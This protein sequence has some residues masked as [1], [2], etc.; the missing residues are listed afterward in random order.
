MFWLYSIAKTVHFI[1]LIS[2]FAGLFYLPRLFI[3]HT[4]AFD[5]EDPQIAAALKNQFLLMEKKLYSIIMTPAMIITF[6]G[7]FSMIGIGIAQGGMIWFLSQTWLLLKLFFIFLL[8]IY[9]HY[10]LKIIKNLSLDIRIMSTTGLRYFN[11]IPTVIML[12]IVMLAVYKHILNFGIAFI[13]VLIFIL[14]L[15]MGIKIYKI[16]REKR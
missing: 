5:H 16:Y 2:W 15:I 4:E 12:I 14:F 7:G 1:G 9:H 13:V 10:N 8:T 3:Y 6:I 11:E